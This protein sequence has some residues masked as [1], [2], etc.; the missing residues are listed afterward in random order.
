MSAALVIVALGLGLIAILI[1]SAVE[2]RLSKLEERYD[3]DHG[4]EGEVFTEDPR[5]LQ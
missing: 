3:Q 1:A 2:S 4:L 5:Y